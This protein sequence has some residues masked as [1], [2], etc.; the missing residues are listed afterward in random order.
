[1]ERGSEVVRGREV[2]GEG[3]KVVVRSGKEGGRQATT[4]TH[5][6]TGE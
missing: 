1:M 2:R 5:G 4:E 6:K 3:V